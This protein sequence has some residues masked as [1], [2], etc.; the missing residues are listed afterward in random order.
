MFVTT[1]TRILE[2]FAQLIRYS[3]AGNVVVRNFEIVD[4]FVTMQS[5]DPPLQTIIQASCIPDDDEIQTVDYHNGTLSLTDSP[6]INYKANGATI[7][8]TQTHYRKI[9]SNATELSIVDVEN[10]P[11]SMYIN[12]GTM[13]DETYFS[14][15]FYKNHYSG[16]MSVA[17][18]L[19]HNTTTIR[20]IYFEHGTEI[21]FAM[22]YIG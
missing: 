7:Q 22:L 13:M 6:Y 9:V 18:I 12:Y 17:S 2:L 3:G 21:D 16:L 20:N 11:I 4:Y 15:S 19:I 1:N 10:S 8:S 5:P 14:D